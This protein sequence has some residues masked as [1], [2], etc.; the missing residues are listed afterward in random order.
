MELNDKNEYTT[1][2]MD[3]TTLN[4]I[5]S[6]N[7]SFLPVSLSFLFSFN[8]NTVIM[9]AGNSTNVGGTAGITKGV[10]NNKVT[11]GL[12]SNFMQSK[13]DQ[14]TVMVITPQFYARAKFGKHHRIKLRLNLISTDNQTNGT[15]TLEEIGDLSYVFSF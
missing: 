9:D 10:W 7:L 13:N 2:N 8:Y 15:T 5:V 3:F 4:H 6:Y 14:Q 12:S 11:L 1:F